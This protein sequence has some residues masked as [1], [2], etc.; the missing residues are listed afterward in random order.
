M[1]LAPTG[2]TLVRAHCC[3][4]RRRHPS[5]DGARSSRICLG[6]RAGPPRGRTKFIMVIADGLSNGERTRQASLYRI[7]VQTHSVRYGIWSREQAVASGACAGRG[8]CRAHLVH[9][10]PARPIGLS[11]PLKALGLAPEQRQSAG[12][13]RLEPGGTAVVWP[14]AGASSNH[15]GSQAHHSQ[16]L[17]LCV[18][19]V[20]EFFHCT[21]S[22]CKRQQTGGV[23]RPGVRPKACSKACKSMRGSGARRARETKGAHSRRPVCASDCIGARLWQAQA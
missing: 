12:D 9:G 10:G 23:G 18:R 4:R 8:R 2:A 5:P 16:F 21:S 20:C 1:R 17:A 6:I 11:W 15:H 7:G 22:L 19:V 13:A 14:R 3:R